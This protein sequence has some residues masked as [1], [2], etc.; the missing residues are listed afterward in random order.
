[1][2]VDFPISG[3]E[4][5]SQPSLLGVDFMLKTKAKLFFDPTNK[6]AYF[7]IED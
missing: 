5:S 3:D 1:M 4:K 2:P 6:E 7:E